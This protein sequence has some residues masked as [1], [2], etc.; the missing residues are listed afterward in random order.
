MEQYLI[1]NEETRNFFNVIKENLSSCHEFK[2]CVSFIR[3][4]GAQLLVDI[5]KEL[6]KQD[7]KGQILTSTYMNVTQPDALEMLSSFKNIKLK[8]YTPNF[9]NGFHAKG[10]LFLN[11]E[12]NDKEK[13]TIIV[14]S[15]NISGAAFKKNVEWNILNHEPLLE[16]NEPS[17]FS[18]SILEEFDKLWQSPFSKDF[19][20][21]FLISYRDYLAKT[22]KNQ[23]SN[24]EIFSFQE[25]I[26][27]PN[28][29]QAE[30]IAKL[31]KL[32]NMNESK[33]LA[34]AATG[35]GK[36]Y[37]SVFDAMQV[38]PNRCLF[39]VHRGDILIKAKESF[40]KIISKTTSNYS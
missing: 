31:A 35:T 14:G 6:D 3:I 1:T 37:M 40:D 4:S 15:S 22:K 5:L 30:A 25:D 16:N 20:D 17:D 38:N 11:P 28:P 23:K 36:T 12:N 33:A 29:M 32:R 2:I 26:V 19:S 21:E 24:K 7:I 9:E 13:W 34:I 18:K 8:I 39:V 27:T 10:Y